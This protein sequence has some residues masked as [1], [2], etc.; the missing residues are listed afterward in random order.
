MS[1]LVAIAFVTLLADGSN[2]RPVPWLGM[3]FN[4]YGAGN[5]RRVLH[6]ERLAAGGPAERAGMRIGDVIVSVGRRPIDFGDELEFLLYLADRA[7]SERLRFGVLRSGQRIDV[8]VT[9][10]VMPPA[11]R[12]GWE[13]SIA[14]ARHRRQEALRRQ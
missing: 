7:P 2:A 14:V 9:L 4:W 1:T 12:P 11:S 6:V 5:G 8:I 3:G 13:R 10:G